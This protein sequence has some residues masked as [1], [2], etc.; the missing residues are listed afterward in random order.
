MI[1]FAAGDPHPSK[2]F[3]W[4]ANDWDR[5]GVSPARPSEATVARP[6]K[7]N[8]RRRACVYPC[9]PPTTARF[10]LY[11]QEGYQRIEVWQSYYNDGDAAIVMEKERTL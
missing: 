5:A 4:I 1:G 2:G 8:W 6:A 11:E 7:L 9:A 3:S 10:R